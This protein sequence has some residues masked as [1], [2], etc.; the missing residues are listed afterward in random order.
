V[1]IILNLLTTS[2]A[3]TA[4]AQEFQPELGKIFNKQENKKN[5]KPGKSGLASNQT[6]YSIIIL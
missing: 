1:N 6:S 4:Q 2:V 3:V 5:D